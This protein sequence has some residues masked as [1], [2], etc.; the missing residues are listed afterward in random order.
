MAAN[1]KTP[2]CIGGV[3]M[4]SR[5]FLAPLAGYTSLAFRLC[6]RELGGL[7]LA[8]TDL[9]NAR[10]LLEKRPRAFELI[11]TCPEDRPLAVQIYGPVKEELCAAAQMLEARSVSIIDLNMGCPAR[12]VVRGGG[13]SALM[14]D[15]CAT[16]AL[17]RTLVES[18]KIPVTV[19][20][21]LG[22]DDANITAP[23]FAREFEQ[24]GVAAITIH[25]RTRE[26]GFG[27]SV[28]RAGI[29]AVVEAVRRIPVV[30]NGDIRTVED[31]RTMFAETGC[32]AVGIGR[33]GLLNPWIF[34]Q[35]EAELSDGEKVAPPAYADRVDFMARHFEKLLEL[36]TEK[37]ACVLFRKIAKWYGIALRVPRPM[38]HRLVM[39]RD[40]AEFRALMAELRATKPAAAAPGSG[41][42]VPVPPGPNER[43]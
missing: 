15:A 38:R 17:V 27:G 18:V 16:V 35:C 30:G 22:W 11:E 37:V 23:F 1:I 40:A 41:P 9:V 42:H 8:T 31:A 4:P 26:Q 3:E 20:M 29:R 28:N 32:A 25:G 34:R 21:R 33:G 19:K 24:A 10:S 12:K 43:W 7:G 6:A 13:G 39:I 2:L 5:F 14:R 36:R